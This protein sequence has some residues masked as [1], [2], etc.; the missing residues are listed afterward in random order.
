MSSQL[1]IVPELFLE[2]NELNRLKK[3][4]SDDISN[5]LKNGSAMYGIVRNGMTDPAFDNFK[6]VAGTNS[7]TIAL[8]NPS[9]AVDKDAL[10]IVQ[11]AFDNVSV[12]T[13]SIYHIVIEHRYISVEQ[14]TVSVAQD[15]GL[16]GTGTDF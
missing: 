12:P 13:G 14:G 5:N 2:S 6:V 4:I 16:T 3:F 15:G 8:Q 10:M 11:E 1:H 7:G 9:V